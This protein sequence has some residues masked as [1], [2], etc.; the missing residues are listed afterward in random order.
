MMFDMESP[1]DLNRV[2]RIALIAKNHGPQFLDNADSF[3]RLLGR[4]RFAE[5]D[6]RSLRDIRRIVEGFANSTAEVRA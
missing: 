4:G 2:L 6:S 5:M 3:D 1:T